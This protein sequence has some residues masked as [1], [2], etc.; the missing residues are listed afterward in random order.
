MAEITGHIPKYQ[1]VFETLRAEILNGRYTPARM[2]PS[3]TMLVRRFGV[4]RSTVKRG[5]EKLVAEGHI[6][7]RQGSQT[8]ITASSQSGSGKIVLIVPGVVHSEFF[9]T[10]CCELI[11]RCQSA[12]RTL[13]MRELASADPDE[14]AREALAFAKD[15]SDEN[16]AGVIFQPLERRKHFKTNR[17][18]VEMFVRRSIPVV[19]LNCDIECAPAR[20]EFD[21]VG[22]D[23][24]E[25]GNCLA[26]HLIRRGATR[27]AF[28][29]WPDVP[30]V[31]NRLRGVR[32]AAEGLDVSVKGYSL[33]P[34]NVPSVRRFLRE[35]R[36]DAIICGNDTAAAYLSHT[37]KALGKSV[38]G[39][40]LLAGF[41]DLQHATIMTPQLTTIHQPCEQIAA[42]AVSRILARIAN[43][44]L[45]PS[46]IFLASPLVVRQ[47]TEPV[48]RVRKT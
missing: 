11:R 14:R 21:L 25:A 15:A 9:Q 39:D 26:N 29:M 42:T 30:S 2:F 38:P 12:G 47:S 16:V 4:G 23:N 8:R 32:L 13:L 44:L 45:P 40:I 33:N 35:F 7:R 31:Y 1:V 20:S 10:I 27:I 3:E 48:R 28:V 6:L 43:P 24:V 46:K 36:P 17:R 41:D 37:L 34:Q 5:L 22:I 18:I 19:L